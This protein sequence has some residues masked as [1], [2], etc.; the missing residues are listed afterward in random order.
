[1][2]TGARGSVGEYRQPRAREP[3]ADT[4]GTIPLPQRTSSEH[5]DRNLLAARQTW[6][7]SQHV[8]SS[9][10]ELRVY[11]GGVGA[12]VSYL[13]YYI[14]GSGPCTQHVPTEAIITPA[15]ALAFSEL[16]SAVERL[17][18]EFTRAI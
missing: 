1:M 17:K 16:R 9:A 15:T 8:V 14:Y 10:S 4:L 13:H 6:T 11:E 12:G 2:S 7:T 3:W 5:L 18:S